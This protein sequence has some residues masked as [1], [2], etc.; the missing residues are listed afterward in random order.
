VLRRN[1]VSAFFPCQ[2]YPLNLPRSRAQQVTNCV[3]ENSIL[4]AIVGSSFLQV[5]FLNLMAN[6]QERGG[7]VKVRVGGNTQETATLVDSTPDGAALEKDYGMS[8][9]PVSANFVY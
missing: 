7:S 6:L 9:N 4:F 8:S 3:T 1:S 2:F 5:P